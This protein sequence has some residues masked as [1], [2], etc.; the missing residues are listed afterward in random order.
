MAVQGDTE[1]L[2]LETTQSEQPLQPFRIPPRRDWLL[3]TPWISSLEDVLKDKGDYVAH[4]FFLLNPNL[5]PTE[6][7][8]GN[9]IEYVMKTL[10]ARNPD[11]KQFP[12]KWTITIELDEIPKELQ[13]PSRTSD[14]KS[15]LP[16]SLLER[17]FLSL[18]E[19][20]G[21]YMLKAT[22]DPGSLTVD[23]MRKPKSCDETTRAVIKIIRHREKY[24]QVIAVERRKPLNSEPQTSI[25][26]KAVGMSSMSADTLAAESTTL[27]GVTGQRS[28]VNGAGTA[29]EHTD[30][31]ADSEQLDGDGDVTT[32]NKR[33]HG[34]PVSQTKRQ[35][36]KN[37]KPAA[38]STVVTTTNTNGSEVLAAS[39]TNNVAEQVS[40]LGESFLIQLLAEVKAERAELAKD[41]E[42][43]RRVQDEVNIRSQELARNLKKYGE[44][45]QNMDRHIKAYGTIRA[46]FIGGKQ[47]TE[48]LI[49][50]L[51]AACVQ[52]IRNSGQDCVHCGAPPDGFYE[53]LKG[54][55]EIIATPAT[56]PATNAPAIDITT[57]ATPPT[58]AL[59]TNT[60]AIPVAN[61][62]GWRLQYRRLKR[63]LRCAACRISRK[64]C[65]HTSITP[66]AAT[67]TPAAPTSITPAAWYLADL[68]GYER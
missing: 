21:S 55:Q 15:L 26:T 42:K 7:T 19:K 33:K 59:T 17:Q 40:S 65:T 27:A 44:L 61:P 62:S 68:G 57:A 56:T 25:P 54:A 38:P 45:E 2:V 28:A 46:E 37:A 43:N 29:L 30:R 39:P 23:R 64:R 51:E 41:I 49:S 4:Q 8:I 35:R 3:P 11:W 67:S 14:S 63:G 18:V 36:I 31:A 22:A 16:T 60:P 58:S 53:L 50:R 20:D 66:A 9:V 1:Y 48:R 24:S 52:V 12:R 32:G 47:D 5:P 10:F 6:F 34:F 13:D